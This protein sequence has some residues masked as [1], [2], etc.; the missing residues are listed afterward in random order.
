M[1]LFSH[2]NARRHDKAIYAHAYDSLLFHLFV[3]KLVISESNNSDMETGLQ[4]MYDLPE[5]QKDR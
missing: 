1:A 3:V 4:K 2:T 5:S